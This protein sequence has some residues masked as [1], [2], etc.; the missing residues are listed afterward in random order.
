MSFSCSMAVLFRRACSRRAKLLMYITLEIPTLLSSPSAVVIAASSLLVRFMRN[1]TRVPGEAFSKSDL[2]H[3]DWHTRQLAIATLRH[4]L[5]HNCIHQHMP[6]YLSAGA[7]QLCVWRTV[8]VWDTDTYWRKMASHSGDVI[9][10]IAAS[11]SLTSMTRWSASS[12]SRLCIKLIRL[13]RRI[14]LNAH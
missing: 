10:E 14:Q 5:E 12:L 4:A 2:F 7:I 9:S 11:W 6:N 8:P 13:C 1:V 3:I